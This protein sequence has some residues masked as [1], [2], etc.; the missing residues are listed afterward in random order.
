M[1]KK[2]F[3]EPT[4]PRIL[5]SSSLLVLSR[6]NALS[7][8]KSVRIT[9]CAQTIYSV[10]TLLQTFLSSLAALTPQETSLL[11]NEFIGARTNSFDSFKQ[12]CRYT[13]SLFALISFVPFLLS[14]TLKNHSTQ[15]SLR[16]SLVTFILKPFHSLRSLHSLLLIDLLLVSL[17]KHISSL[18]K[19]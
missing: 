13:R 15:S 12:I 8:T 10:V 7:T 9:R 4:L 3:Y 6:A 2:Y 17:V 11:M 5:K 16:S 14:F 18:N 19:G 1:P